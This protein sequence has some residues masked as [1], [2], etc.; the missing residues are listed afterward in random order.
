MTTGISSST[1][2][3]TRPLAFAGLNGVRPDPEAMALTNPEQ[4]EQRQHDESGQQAAHEQIA[5]RHSG[6]E[7]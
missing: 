1:S 3:A 4:R 7:P 2:P 6:H 5:N